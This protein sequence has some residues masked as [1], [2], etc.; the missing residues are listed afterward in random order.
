MR[1]SSQ[2]D[3]IWRDLRDCSEE[4]GKGV[5]IYRSLYQEGAGSLFIKE[6]QISR[7]W[8]FFYVREDASVWTHWIHSFY[9][10]LSCL[11]PN[12]A[13][14]LLSLLLFSHSSHVWL[15]VIP[16]T[17]T[18]QASLSFTIS[19]N[20]LKLM[21]T[22]SVISSNHLILCRP[23][24]SCPQFFPASGSFPMSRLFT[25]GGQNI[26]A[27]ASASV[28]PMNIQGWFPIVLTGLIFL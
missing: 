23:F 28:L 24:S 26:G 12:P 27:S 5:G 18:S 17:A 7:N 15:F 10:P 21:S 14:W 22:E 8:T 4:V 20:L 6:N 16:R 2:G 25:K 13:S 9:M 11:G 1:T 19:C 3:S